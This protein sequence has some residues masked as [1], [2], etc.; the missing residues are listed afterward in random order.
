MKKIICG[1]ITV[2]LF[3]S[4]V[5]SETLSPKDVVKGYYEETN[6]DAFDMELI[7]SIIFGDYLQGLG[8]NKRTRFLN[9]MTEVFNKNSVKKSFYK[10]I[11]PRKKI[12]SYTIINEKV[13]NEHAEV[14]V[15]HVMKNR[16][17]D[18]QLY[19]L[20]TISGKWKI[21][22]VLYQGAD[23]EKKKMQKKI[24]DLFRK[25]EKKYGS[26]EKMMEIMKKNIEERFNRQ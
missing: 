5:Q 7:L 4:L 24:G 21:Y 2:L 20:K 26:F 14:E 17:E 16:Q 12:I 1:F 9:L 25:L 23:L 15:K 6:Y 19:K 3:I 13:Q 8:E 22:D 11:N 10:D 18:K